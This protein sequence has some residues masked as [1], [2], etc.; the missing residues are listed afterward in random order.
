MSF[1]IVFLLFIAGIMIL[2]R[3]FKKL[4]AKPGKSGRT[5][6]GWKK[7][8]EQLIE[9]L[10]RQAESSKKRAGSEEWPESSPGRQEDA[11]LQ[12]QYHYGTA[13]PHE[14]EPPAGEEAKEK[15][16]RKQEQQKYEPAGRER[17]TYTPQASPYSAYR[18]KRMRISR[19]KLRQAVIWSEILSKPAALRDDNYFEKR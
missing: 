13:V 10:N 5:A 3:V 18:R 15:P 12:E 4:A 16:Y 6:L 9:E 17:R 7:G 1:E 11:A 14:Y 8:L 19:E 2:S